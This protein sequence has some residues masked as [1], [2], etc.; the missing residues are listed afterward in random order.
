MNYEELVEFLG[1]ENGAEFEYFE[2][3][4]DLIEADEEILDEALYKLFKDADKSTVMDLLENYFEDILKSIPD[5][6]TDIFML[7]ESVKMSFIGLVETIDS[8]VEEYETALVHF[9]E[10][11]NNFKNWYSKDSKVE[12][13]KIAD[14]VKEV[15]PV[16]DA[17]VYARLEKLDGEKYQYDFQECMDYSPEEYVLTYGDLARAMDENQGEQSAEYI[18]DYS[19]FDLIEE[20]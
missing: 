3:L 17:L 20:Y 1:I 5:D 9:C 18:D 13:I 8:E 16:R 6:A 19:E 2:N 14:G 10:E 7:I 15:L 12:C 4:A 11:L